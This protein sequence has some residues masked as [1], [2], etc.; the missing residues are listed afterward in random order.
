MSE[1]SR[2]AGNAKRARKLSEE[3][4]ALLQRRGGVNDAIRAS[5]ESTGMARA[6]WT[7]R[8]APLSSWQESIWFIDRLEPELAIYNRPAWL[9]LR[10]KLDYGALEQSLREIF[11]RHAVLRSRVVLEDERPVQIRLDDFDFRLPVVDL[12]AHRDNERAS[13]YASIVEME[14]R[15]GFDLSSGPFARGRL[16]RL[17]DDEHVLLFT[18]HHIAFDGWSADVFFRELGEL[19]GARAMRRPSTLPELEF[20]YADFASWQRK[21]LGAASVEQAVA[22]WLAQLAGAPPLLELPSDRKRPAVRT[23]AAGRVSA[24]L[25]TRLVRELQLI[26]R[27]EDATL[28]MT[29]LA[30]TQLLLSR[31]S[32]E[33]DIVIGVPVAGRTQRATES[34]LGCF[35]NVL[36]IRTCVTDDC[37]FRQLLARVRATVLDAFT[38]QDLPFDVLVERL[39]PERSSSH[40]PVTQVLFNYRNTPAPELEF[41]GLAASPEVPPA[42]TVIPDLEIDIEQGADGLRC[43][44]LYS[45]ELFD[46]STI[47]RWLGHFRTLLEGIVTAP[48]EQSSRLP[49]LSESERRG[50]LEDWN[51]AGRDYSEAGTIEAL[52]EDAAR[53]SPDAIAVVAGDATLSY[54]ELNDRANQLAHELMKRGAAS[55]VLVGLYVDRSPAMMIALLGIMKSGAAYVPLDSSLPAER[56]GYMMRDSGI[57]IMVVGGAARASVPQFGGDVVDVDDE[58]LRMNSR[59]NPGV[60]TSGDATAYVIY[61]SGSTGTPKG[62]QVTRRA[63]TNLLLSAREWFGLSRAERLLAVASISFD[64]AGVDVW[65]P[66]IVGATTVVASREDAA[67]GERLRALI[68][69]HDVTF[70]QATPATWQLLLASGWSGKGDMQCVSSGDVLP[71]DVGARLAA[72]TGRTWNLYG[73]TETT[74]WSTGF[75]LDDP[76]R[77]MLIGRPIANTRC[78]VLDSHRNPQPPG[79]IGELWIAG[80]GVARGYLNAPELTRDR[81]VADTFSDMEGDRMY[82]SGD[83]AR[84]TADGNLELAGR[85]DTQVKIRGFRIELGEIE[86]VLERHARIE[87]A[88]VVVREDVVGDK[89]LVAYVVA[90]G[91]MPHPDD[92][93]AHLAAFVPDY[94]LPS[95]YAELGAMPL[96]A[97]GKI[98][99]RAL[100]QLDAPHSTA[101][102]IDV[103]PNGYVEQQ[104]RQIWVELLGRDDVGVA[105]DFFRLGGHSLLAVAMMERVAAVFGIRPPLSVLFAAPTIQRLAAALVDRAQPDDSPIVCVQE[106][107]QGRAPFF[108]FHGDIAGSGL[109]SRR[110]AKYLDAAQP[111]FTMGPHRIGG[112]ATIHAMAADLLPH[113][114]AVQPTGPY[115]FAGYCNGGMVALEI[116]Q[117]LRARGDAVDMLAVIDA[118]AQNAQLRILADVVRRITRIAGFDERRQTDTFMRMHEPALRFLREE[119]PPIDK[120]SGFGARIRF[121]GA[122]AALILRRASRR[123]WRSALGAVGLRQPEPA[124]VEDGPEK[125]T[126]ETRRLRRELAHI[127]RAMRSYIPLEY[128]GTI[129][130]IGASDGTMGGAGDQLRHWRAVGKQVEHVVIPGDHN[131][132]VTDNLDSLAA[133]LDV[134]LRRL[135]G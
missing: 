74:I 82:R 105:D 27:S 64:I 76:G 130:V 73:P 81:F 33:D 2:P 104:L 80:G 102:S 3:A 112:P 96:T 21:R 30:A 58:S 91:D 111:V 61:T 135:A 87:Q 71:P 49:L 44:A 4:Q 124:V 114:V 35:I 85:A 38:H 107:E 92:L 97:N 129:T 109:Y 42:T 45:T 119:L 6:Q 8:S 56:I 13:A 10:G 65:L 69:R 67:D 28:F 54:R 83:L 19:Y 123:V 52:V 93:R 108:L 29:M 37:S 20:Q 68:D 18:A 77:P 63:L 22:Y 95:A 62:V 90:D 106:G 117:R 60:A 59:A 14:A 50:I 126:P 40:T 99:R 32:G 48:D 11:R 23:H 51:P 94:M 15:A 72:C 36:P 34:M 133:E 88:A 79:V 118:S 115:Y 100:L 110:L 1:E 5:G 25:P 43:V 53:Q 89:R 12:A 101:D 26:G 128:D 86:S 127:T 9:R 70:M 31:L 24:V 116:A 125:L 17:S 75:L 132:I 55:D 122:L 98:D 120:S 134:R 41:E 121:A 16:I 46:G 7:G 57:G 66:W 131:T 39:K 113:V 78:Y 47:E 103:A 84:Y